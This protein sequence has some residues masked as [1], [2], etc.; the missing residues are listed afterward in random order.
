MFLWKASMWLKVVVGLKLPTS[1]NWL[2]LAHHHPVLL[3]IEFQVEVGVEGN[4]RNTHGISMYIILH[5]YPAVIKHGNLASL[6]WKIN[7]HYL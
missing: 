6:N 1:L 3:E 5:G 2:E 7:V 4:Q